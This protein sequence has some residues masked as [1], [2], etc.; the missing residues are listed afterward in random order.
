M[1]LHNLITNRGVQPMVAVDP[2]ADLGIPELDNLISV[3]NG[4]S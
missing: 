4:R 1:L 3:H 2:T